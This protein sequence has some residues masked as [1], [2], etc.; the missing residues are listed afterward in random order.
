MDEQ[1][2]LEDDTNK[3][4]NSVK[5]P[6][7]QVPP[8][9]SSATAE[10]ADLPM[11]PSINDEP[12]IIYICS[13]N[14]SKQKQL[15]SI[16]DELNPSYSVLYY[17]ADTKDDD[18]DERK[19][20]N[21]EENDVMAIG[22]IRF[23]TTLQAEKVYA[24]VN[25]TS[26]PSSVPSTSSLSPTIIQ[27]RYNS[28][29][30]HYHGDTTT[31]LVDNL[32]DT[33][34]ISSIYDLL[35]QY[36][37]IAKCRRV[38]NT[39]YD[40]GKVQS[41]STPSLEKRVEV[42]FFRKEDANYAQTQ[43]SR[44]S[45]DDHDLSITVITG[46]P[47][48][49]KPIAHRDRLGNTNSA[50]VTCDPPPPKKLDD[51]QAQQRQQHQLQVEIKPSMDLCNLYIKGLS[52]S[53]TSNE[54]FNLF[55][56]HGRII[57]ARVMANEQ[58]VSKG[59]GFV[60][61]SQPIEAASALVH[62]HQHYSILFHEPKVP[63]SDHDIQQQY[64][65]LAHSPL[66]GYFYSTTVSLPSPPAALDTA[67]NP[68]MTGMPPPP[69]AAAAAA[70]ASMPPP[71]P[72]LGTGMPYYLYSAAPP[73]P[74]PPFGYPPTTPYYYHHPPPPPPPHMYYAPYPYSTPPIPSTS[75][76]VVQRCEMQQAVQQALTN[77][78]Q[79]QDMVDMLM[80]LDETEKQQCLTDIA[81]LK[82]KMDQFHG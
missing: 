66:G 30:R 56:P 14:Q 18:N 4:A 42:E 20:S 63:R 11:A 45:F 35:R 69:A 23:P 75:P 9:S 3:A 70:A 38:C 27:L 64:W 81:Y 58:G 15:E 26:L 34:S 71:P 74:P 41:Q 12:A 73:P 1:Q 77:D 55:K 24:L 43:L 72:P 36:G 29:S 46:I 5:S 28:F 48:R 6:Q 17:S 62:L 79:Q 65:S 2:H 8:A 19:M 7:P 51:K 53:M 80:N 21:S 25:G 50:Q 67:T 49:S 10:V 61:F 37:P 60:S 39:E 78:K 82:E 40:I 52:L 13:P 54:L 44:I 22:S 32:P 57:S 68:T 59:F 31:L 47:N 76:S 33:M 16:L